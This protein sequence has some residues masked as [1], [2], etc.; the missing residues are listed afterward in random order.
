MFIGDV[1]AKACLFTVCDVS[2]CVCVRVRVRV[3]V[4]TCVYFWVLISYVCILC[5]S[6]YCMCCMY[7][8]T[9][10][11]LIIC[12]T[13]HWMLLVHRVW[14]LSE[15]W[16]QCT[17]HVCF[18]SHRDTVWRLIFVLIVC[19]FYVTQRY[20]LKININA[21]WTFILHHTGIRYESLYQHSSNV[22][23]T[24]RVDNVWL[25]V[26]MLIEWSFYLTQGYGLNFCISAHWTFVLHHT[27]IRS[28]IVLY[29]LF[30][31]T[32]IVFYH[33]C[34]NCFISHG[35]DITCDYVTQWWNR[36]T[37]DRDTV[38]SKSRSERNGLNFCISIH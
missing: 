11:S 9:A 26:S 5:V 3:R 14:I 4:S 17:L 25:S 24:S 1:Y 10:R 29:K 18:L 27:G 2:V 33:E 15:C 7:I 28:K 22:C 12:F 35:D 16:F 31:I 20:G 30:H 36:F 38:S 32:Q 13:V 21:R 19:L 34:L 8:C 37:S 23:C 6:T